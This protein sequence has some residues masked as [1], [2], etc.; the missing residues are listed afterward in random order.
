MASWPPKDNVLHDFIERNMSPKGKGRGEGLWLKPQEA[1]YWYGTE[2]V[3]KA[4]G[5]KEWG[6]R[7]IIDSQKW[8][9]QPYVDDEVRGAVKFIGETLDAQPEGEF[10]FREN[11]CLKGWANVVDEIMELNPKEAELTQDCFRI[12]IA[13]C[14]MPANKGA[15]RATKVRARAQAL[16]PNNELATKVVELLS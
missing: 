15:F 13:G 14:K 10:S 8:G 2:I 6:A 12:V 5:A 3:A 9:L 7:W 11:L 16:G 1:L 4:A